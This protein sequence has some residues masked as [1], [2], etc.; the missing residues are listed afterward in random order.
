MSYGLLAEKILQDA[1]NEVLLRRVYLLIDDMYE[2]N[3]STLEDVLGV[4]LLE[5]LAQDPLLAAK[6]RA[7]LAPGPRKMMEETETRFY[8]RT[9]G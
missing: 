9:L 8:G 2:S 6:I 5:G 4:S 1:D 7:H 3:D